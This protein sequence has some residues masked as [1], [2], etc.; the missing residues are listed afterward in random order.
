MND[1]LNLENT[2][3][4]IIKGDTPRESVLKGFEMLGGISTFI[5]EGDKVFIKYNLNLPGG[6]PTNT[7]FDV[8][9]AVIGLCKNAKAEKICLG[10]FPL[11]GVPIK[12]ISN[13]QN[14]EECFRNIGAELIYLDNSNLFDEKKLEKDQ[15]N[16]IKTESF[17]IFNINNREYL[18][19]RVI[20]DSDKL[21]SVN[22]VNVNPLFKINSSLLNS[23]SIVSPKYQESGVNK[24]DE[25]E[26]LS[27]DRYK[28][29]LISNI[30]DIY[31]IKKPD[32]VINDLFY[33]LEGAGPFIY[34]DSNLKKTNFVV[35]GKNSVSVDFITLKLLNIETK[36]DDLIKEAYKRNL[37]IID[38]EKIEIL[39]EDLDENDVNIDLCVSKLED[40]NVKNFRVNSGKSCSGCFK[41]AYHLLNFMKTN[42]VKD[43][44][45]NPNNVFL[46]GQNPPEPDYFGNILLFGDCAINST[47]NSNFRMITIESKKNVVDETK[48]K[49]LKKQ[50]SQKK[51]KTKIKTNKKILELPGCPPDIFGCLNMFIK[52]YGKSNMPNLSFLEENL[53]TWINP[54]DK[55]YLREMEVL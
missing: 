12:K 18:V 17:S 15:L 27:R 48:D 11:K 26:Y 31:A 3:V 45:Y 50:K 25:S 38:L 52:Y 53:K 34:K 43:L 1:K 55:K 4:A 14:L 30:L 37:G 51:P 20:L 32:I 29:T 49:I 9:A 5:D 7:N 13:L 54:K 24:T 46:V 2:E 16:K 28:T 10:S 19:P 33:V 22:Q 47:K 44:K 42:M 8:L 6:F 35:I 36:D 21:I 39:G 23:S 40:I 41:S